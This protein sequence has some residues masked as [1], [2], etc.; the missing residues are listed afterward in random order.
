MLEPP[1]LQPAS[2]PASLPTSVPPQPPPAAPVAPAPLQPMAP[3]QSAASAAST[4]PASEQALLFRAIRSLR[5]QHRPEEALATLDLYLARFPSGSLMPEAAR[6][7]TEALLALGQKPAALAE[8]NR[9]LG[10][11]TAGEQEHRL[12]RGELRAAAG[13]WQEALEDF[14]AVARGR[15]A[16]EPAAGPAASAKLRDYLERALWGRA[17][18]RS[19]LGDAAGARADLRDYLQRFP[20]GRFA[21]QGARLLGELH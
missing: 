15:L 7:R 14:D 4:P 3:R 18:A 5:S 21:A 17:S 20:Q 13:R 2:V 1:Q 8:L 6:L 16:H 12:V 11:G 10:N 9:G 19:H